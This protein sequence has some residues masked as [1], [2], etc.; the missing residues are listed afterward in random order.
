LNYDGL[1]VHSSEGWVPLI[2]Q[3]ESWEGDLVEGP[4]II[5]R[6]N[7]YYL[8]YS[9]NSYCNDKYAVGVARS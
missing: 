3:D 8:F 6:N 4:W 5:H 2:K 7:Y 1:S 9:A